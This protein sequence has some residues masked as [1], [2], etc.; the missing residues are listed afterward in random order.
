MIQEKIHLIK[1]SIDNKIR[2][3]NKIGLLDGK[4]GAILFYLHY[5]KIFNDTDSYNKASD[6]IE[7]IYN[8]LDFKN[9]NSN[10]CSGISGFFWLLEFIEGKKIMD[11]SFDDLLYD[12]DDLIIDRLD[13]FCNHNNH[14]FLYGSL[15]VGYYLNS[16]L[17]TTGFSKEK[18][19][20][21]IENHVNN[22][23]ESSIN[24]DQTIKWISNTFKNEP[25]ID[26]YLSLPHGFLGI[27]SI[28][29]KYGE[30]KLLLQKLSLKITLKK[31]YNYL[32]QDFQNLN[33]KRN[34][35]Y[36]LFESIPNS[37]TRLAWCNGD[38]SVVITL[39]NMHNLLHEDN[40]ILNTIVKISETTSK[41]KDINDTQINDIYLCHGSLGLV[42]IYESLYNKTK[43]DSFKE[44]KD[45]WLS[46]S[47][48][49][50]EENPSVLNDCDISLLTGLTGVGLTLL[51]EM[52]TSLRDWK[53]CILIN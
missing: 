5:Y 33:I 9:F 8:G 49:K 34:S 38:L 21:A 26:I 41:R 46:Y 31:A 22:L 4:S 6:L 29:S 37:S 42:N 27:Y 25:K 36:P 50:I 18:Y 24:N 12:I 45:Y 47:I 16:R 32:L 2:N 10:F 1:K 15:G 52:D 17:N 43:N 23:L 7:E 51:S 53:N 3:E 13:I 14:D 11:D 28:L 44:A 40:D 48:K 19:L 39:L 30:N 35:I 20:N